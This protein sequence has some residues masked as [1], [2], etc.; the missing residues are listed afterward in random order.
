MTHRVSNPKRALLALVAVLALAAAGCAEGGTAGGGEAGGEPIRLGAVVPSTGPVA[1]WGKGNTAILEM[2]EEE[3]NAEGGIGGR[4]LEIIIYD[5]AARPEEAA[6]LVRRLASDDQVL[7]IVGPF[8]SSEAEVAFPVCNQE[9]I[10]CTAQASSKP[11]VAEQNRPWAFRNTIDEGTYLNWVTPMVVSEEGIERVAIA[12]DSADAVGTAIGTAIM[13]A[14]FSEA[15]LEVINEANPI[16]FKTE[17]VDVQA[18][19]TSLS[20][21]DAG[22]LG[23]GAFYNGAVKIIQEMTRQ[24]M[25]MPILGGSPL[26]SSS[27]LQPAPEIPIYAAGTYF[28]GLEAAEE[29]TERAEQAYEDNGLPGDPLMFDLQTYE[30]G[31]MYID[32]ILEQGLEAEG[33]D[34]AEART[35]IR[36]FM[37]GLENYPGVTGK[38]SFKETGDAVR[39]FFVIRGLEGG[40]EELEQVPI[41]EQ[42]Q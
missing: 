8:T 38:I 42:E 32:A 39:D 27:I 3:V 13:P 15:G 20:G 26:V 19:V 4:Q 1:E 9:E 6:N 21:L 18:Q 29:W 17:D 7:A 2:L 25:N 14:V 30:I 31:R 33:T 16:T 34:L 11:G 5:S 12:Y 35:A 36:E 10:V 23:I 40:W 37:E 24:G 22:A 28:V 41:E